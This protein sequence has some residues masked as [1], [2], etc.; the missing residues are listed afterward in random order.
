MHRVFRVVFGC[1]D[2]TGFELLLD[3]RL[4]LTDREGERAFAQFEKVHFLPWLENLPAD[5]EF[6]LIIAIGQPAAFQDVIQALFLRDLRTVAVIDFLAVET[7][8]DA[9]VAVIAV[10]KDD[11]ADLGGILAGAIVGGVEDDVGGEVLQVL[12]A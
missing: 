4:V 1:F 10:L 6:F 7:D 9:R 12:T 8:F 11:R 5:L 2:F 3:F